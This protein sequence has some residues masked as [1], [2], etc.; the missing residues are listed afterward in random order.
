MASQSN[1][2]KV[3]RVT[4]KHDNYKAEVDTYCLGERYKI[5]GPPRGS[6]ENKAL[7]DLLRIRASA[8]K[9]STR[10][11]GLESMR[12]VAQEL[13]DAAK[14]AQSNQP[15]KVEGGI[16]ARPPYSY[17]ARIQ[18]RDTHGYHVIIGPIRTSQRRAEADLAKLREASQGHDTWSHQLRAVQAEVEQLII[19]AV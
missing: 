6:D 5:T 4:K 16:E 18:Y 14:V 8:E 9:A 1:W 12:S 11:E 3:G 19:Q 10:A 17:R 7:D 2:A 13:R 15:R